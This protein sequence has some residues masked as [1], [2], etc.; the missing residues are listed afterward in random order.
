[1]LAPILPEKYESITKEW[2]AIFEEFSNAKDEIDFRRINREFI[3]F[4]TRSGQVSKMIQNGTNE[5]KII[6][7]I[8][9]NRAAYYSKQQSLDETKISLLIEYLNSRRNK[10]AFDELRKGIRRIGAQKRNKNVQTQ[11]KGSK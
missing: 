4:A 5:N 11:G 8:V 2:Q 7:W 10:Q 3:S 6:N 9:G 1:M